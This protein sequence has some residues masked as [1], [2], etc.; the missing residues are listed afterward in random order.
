MTEPIACNLSV[1]TPEER[2]AHE[3]IWEQ[4][5]AAALDQR[6]D[7]EAMRFRL[8][9]DYWLMAAQFVARERRCCPF[10]DFRLDLKADGECWLSLGGP[11]EARA[12]LA[13]LS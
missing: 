11:P 4:L 3:N 12:L 1:F 5:Q 7:D 2:A 9:A 13:E 8:P 6:Q 10:F